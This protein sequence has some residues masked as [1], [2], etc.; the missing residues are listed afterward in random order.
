MA[1]A[2]TVAL[3]LQAVDEASEVIDRVQENLDALTDQANETADQ[4]SSSVDSM[5]DSM[6]AFS[7]TSTETATVVQEWAGSVDEATAAAS[8]WAD[9]TTEAVA[10]LQ[11]QAEALTESVAAT[12]EETN[13]LYGLTGASGGAS[14]GLDAVT[15]SSD[16]AGVSMKSLGKATNILGLAF[17]AAAAVGI[18]MAL[19]FQNATASLQG[20]ADIS[21]NAANQIANAFLNA[22]GQVDYT[23]NEMMDAFAPVSGSFVNM[24]GHALNA[25]QSLKF[26]DAAMELAEATGGDLTS[27]TSALASA[28]MVYH[29]RVGEASTASNDLFNI[30]RLLGVSSDDLGT[31]LTKL[32]PMIAGSGMSLAQ[33]GGFMTELAK[34]AGSGMMAMRAAGKA[35]AALV[36]PS[37]SA[38]TALAEL[39]I[40]LDNSQGKFIGMTAAIGDIH[41]ALAKLPGTARDVA[42]AQKAYTLQMQEA[43]LASG[44]QTAAV[45]TQE[46]ALSTQISGLNLNADALSK[47]AVMQQLFGASAG[48]MTSIVAGGAPALERAAAAVAKQGAAAKAAA[49]QQRS[50]EGQLRRLRSAA[51]ALFIR[52]GQY[53]IPVLTRLAMDVIG[54]VNAIGKWVSHNKAL[55]EVIVG[56]VVGLVALVKVIQLVTWATKMW[57]AAQEVLDAIMDMNP[58]ILAIAAVV[59]AVILLVVYWKQIKDAAVDT[60]HAIEDAWGKVAGWFENDVIK[61]VTGFFLDLWHG[62][63]MAAETA[64]NFIQGAWSTVAGWFANNVVQPVVGAF[65]GLWQSLSGGAEAVWSTIQGVWGTVSAWFDNNVVAPIEGFFTA[66]WDT[67]SSLAAGAWDLIESVAVDA[68]HGIETAWDAVRGF[69]TGLWDDVLSGAQVDWDAIKTVAVDVWHAIVAAWEAAVGFFTAVW[70]GIR[71]VVWTVLDGIKSVAETVA[72]FF[73]GVWDAISGAAGAAWDAIVGVWDT[74]AGWFYSHVIEPIE[75]FFTHLWDDIV[76]GVKTAWKDITGIVGSI[77]H[78]GGGLI[79]DALNVVGLASGGLVNAPT[80]AVV[81]EA[82]PEMVIPLSTLP[83]GAGVVSGGNVTPL[84]LSA[85]AVS[86]GASSAPVININFSG[87]VYGSLA[88][89]A[90]TLGRY[91]ATTTV[92]GAGVRLTAR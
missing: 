68:W 7:D 4:M 22:G 52:L 14:D 2:L 46:S 91:L 90:N 19:D 79:G 60:W 80:L 16:S 82:G 28:M 85:A 27:T 25:A 13:A 51:E 72:N 38:Q 86:S 31:S 32:E 71:S 21:T 56:V 17:V 53:L 65:S 30:T 57:A 39:G 48:L 40:D 26:M 11:A 78:T 15:A 1:D 88:Q 84:P 43:T 47:T 66:L 50:F 45:K 6:D 62:I 20:H 73:V 81:G 37:S 64:W 76:N 35:I 92:P 18:K 29:L 75:Q 5:T 41:D 54:M 89:M 87:Q 49:E 33:T 42:D 83:G 34:S 61:P 67:I 63:T 44:V 9:A 36:S 77:V 55:A 24:Y 69:F 74:V 8:A 10:A 3:L 70:N 23:A 59:A 58:I 12:I